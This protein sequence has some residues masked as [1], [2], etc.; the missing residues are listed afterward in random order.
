MYY[1]DF[2]FDI[3][4]GG[5]VGWCRT[6]KVN[7]IRRLRAYGIGSLVLAWLEPNCEFV[8][9]LCLLYYKVKAPQCLASQVWK[10]KR[11]FYTVGMMSRERGLHWHLQTKL[12]R[13]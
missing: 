7:W 4:R 12:E 6:V 10:L 1:E 11:L 3:K 8:W 9:T 13:N 5:K 2:L